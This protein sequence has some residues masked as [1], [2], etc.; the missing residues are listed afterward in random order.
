MCL[1]GLQEI[2]KY[3]RINNN[4]LDL[5]LR[6]LDTSIANRLQPPEPQGGGGGVRYDL[7]TPLE[8]QYFNLLYGPWEGDGGMADLGLVL[9]VDEPLQMSGLNIL[10]RSL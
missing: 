8:D 9:Q 3:W 5:F 2:Q 7:E 4:V 6:Y 1:L 10:E